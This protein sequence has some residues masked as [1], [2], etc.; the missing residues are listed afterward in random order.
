MSGS[1]GVSSLEPRPFTIQAAAGH[2]EVA[3]TQLPVEG[4]A[5]PETDILPSTIASNEPVE[6]SKEARCP[7]KWQGMISK[8]NSDSKTGTDCRKATE[9]DLHVCS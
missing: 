6:A 3:I 9:Q 7:Q 2:A 5:A 8:F 4:T 1:S